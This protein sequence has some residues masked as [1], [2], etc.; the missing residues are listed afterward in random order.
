MLQ[1]YLLTCLIACSSPSF[2]HGPLNSYEHASEGPKWTRIERILAVA[3][4]IQIDRHL[5]PAKMFCLNMKIDLELGCCV[6]DATEDGCS[7][8]PGWVG[9]WLSQSTSSR[10]QGLTK[11]RL[12]NTVLD[13]LATKP[14]T[15]FSFLSIYFFLS[16][17]LFFCRSDLKLIHQHVRHQTQLTCW[18]TFLPLWPISHT[19]NLTLL[20]HVHVQHCI[21]V[22]NDVLQL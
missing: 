18:P 16:F 1:A 21:F 4:V 17:F 19:N 2:T 5:Y 22:S 3:L 20:L 10:A 9:G 7:E 11:T 15:T 14:T 13:C 8:V 12:D 6:R